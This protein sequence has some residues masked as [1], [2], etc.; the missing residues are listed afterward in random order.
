MY[1]D[2]NSTL[3]NCIANFLLEQKHTNTPTFQHIYRNTPLSS[4]KLTRNMLW[5]GNVFCL[6]LR[7]FANKHL[8]GF[9]LYESSIK[10][11]ISHRCSCNTLL[12]RHLERTSHVSRNWTSPIYTCVCIH[13]WIW[14]K[15]KRKAIFYVFCKTPARDQIPSKDLNSSNHLIQERDMP[16]MQK[17]HG[18]TSNLSNIFCW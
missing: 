1:V 4:Q 8:Q 3:K 11:I 12:P 18:F 17:K 9:V 7:D 16:R 13:H 6:I 14:D 5:N 15:K 10:T 2:F